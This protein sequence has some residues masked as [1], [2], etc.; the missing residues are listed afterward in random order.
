MLSKSLFLTLCTLL[1]SAAAFSVQDTN[2]SRRN[3]LTTLTTGAA[4]SAAAVIAAPNVAIAGPEI[5]KL[6]SGIKYAITKPVE[7]GQ[8][9]LQ[10]DFVVIE[11]TGYLTNGQ[12]SQVKCKNAEGDRKV[13]ES[14]AQTDGKC[15]I[16]Y[17]CS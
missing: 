11:Y 10:G 9:P 6:D 15:M 4:A 3:F 1:S 7:K 13:Q 17:G 14:R 12:V 16:R 2:N 8:R 5:L